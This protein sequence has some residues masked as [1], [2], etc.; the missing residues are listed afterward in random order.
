MP[1]S[2]NAVI[3]LLCRLLDK[4][5][6]LI[7][8]TLLAELFFSREPIDVEV[9]FCDNFITSDR[10]GAG[11]VVTLT[12]AYSCTVAAPSWLLIEIWEARLRLSFFTSTC[13]V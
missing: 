5:R 10:C 11:M 6:G 3:V 1:W 2:F 8:L 4:A 13:L 9:L 7:F 12:G